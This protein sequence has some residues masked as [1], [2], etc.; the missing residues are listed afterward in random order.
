MRSLDVDLPGG[1]AHPHQPASPDP[2]TRLIALEPHSVGVP[3]PDFTGW[4]VE[5]SWFFG[6]HKTYEEDGRWGRP[7]INNPM[8]HGSGGWGA[9]QIVG[10][11]RRPRP[12]RQLGQ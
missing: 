11:Y 10:K 9:L 12:E 7:K 3:D 8:F 6:G 2:G 4:Y 5:G 1:A